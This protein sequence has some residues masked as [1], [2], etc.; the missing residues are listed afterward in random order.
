MGG[1]VITTFSPVFGVE[2]RVGA[3]VRAAIGMRSALA[4]FNRSGGYPEVF[5]GIGIHP[6][7]LVAGNVGTDRRME[8]TALGGTVNA[9][10]RIES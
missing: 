4:E 2:D 3:A 7:R 8:Y 9:T 5:A 10:S 1:A 6:G